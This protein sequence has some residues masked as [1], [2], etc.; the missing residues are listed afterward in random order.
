MAVI[1][2]PNSIAW[3]EPVHRALAESDP[4]KILGQVYAAEEALFHRWQQLASRDDRRE[5][6][7]EMD[8][9]AQD[10]MRIQIEKMGWP[11]LRL[12]NSVKESARPSAM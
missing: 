8:Q 5:E 7:R 9:A 4:A 3:R 12:E 1:I 6:L 10:L 11:P 2:E